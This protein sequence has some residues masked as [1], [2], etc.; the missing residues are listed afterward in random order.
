MP[1]RIY[2]RTRRDPCALRVPTLPAASPSSAGSAR[3]LTLPRHFNTISTMSV[4]SITGV[5]SSS[6]VVFGFYIYA[7]GYSC[8]LRVSAVASLPQQYL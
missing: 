4:I 7:R 8:T 1:E 5:I 3:S 2:T 6:L